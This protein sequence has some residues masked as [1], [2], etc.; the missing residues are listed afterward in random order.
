VAIAVRSSV[1]NG[2]STG[3][4]DLT[5]LLQ[6]TLY[7]LRITIAVHRSAPGADPGEANPQAL[8]G[9]ALDGHGSA[10]TAMDN[11]LLVYTF[12]GTAIPAGRVVAAA[13]FDFT[14]GRQNQDGAHCYGRDTYAVR[15]ATTPSGSLTTLAGHF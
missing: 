14:S 13:R 2:L 4:D 8:P 1:T 15:Y 7:R 11:G 12:T 3:E 5:L 10:H 6:V 9:G